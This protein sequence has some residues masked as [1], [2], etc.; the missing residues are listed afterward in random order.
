[1][2]RR[3]GDSVALREIWRGRVWSAVP[4]TVVQDRDDEQRLF[5]PAGT[6]WKSPRASDGRWLRLP[7]AEWSLDDRTPEPARA[8][9]SF[10]FAG[11]AFAVMLFWDEGWRPL[12]WYVNLQAPLRRTPVGFDS[13]DHVLDLLV[14]PDRSCWEW[15]DENELEDA[16]RRGLFTPGEAQAFRA[17]GEAALRLLVEGRPPFDRDWT[18]WRPDPAWSPPSLPAGWDRI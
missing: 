2:R 14:A 15:K 18:G 9:L 11:R 6:S 10:A 7:E 1:M 12:T 16:V 4:A 8:V 13:V 5:V 17:D 3:P